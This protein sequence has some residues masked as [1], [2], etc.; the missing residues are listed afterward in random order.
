VTQPRDYRDYLEDVRQEATLALAFLGDATLDAFTQDRKTH[1]A[2]V[3]ALEIVGEA[4]RHIPQDVRDRYPDV[5]WQRM[6]GMRNRV[7]HDYL[8]VDLEV[9]Y[10][11][12]R[13]DLPPLIARLTAILRELGR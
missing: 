5:P 9:V 7:I 10:T 12:V 13:D 3:R 1:Y 11:T 8:G 4:T 2:V 6:A